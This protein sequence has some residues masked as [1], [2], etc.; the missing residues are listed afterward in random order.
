MAWLT[1]ETHNPKYRALVLRRNSDDLRDWVDRASQL[2]SRLVNPGTKVGNPPEFRFPSGAIIRTGHL[3]D[4]QAYT[5][6]QG[7]EY[8]R[9]LIEELTQIAEERQYLRLLSSCRSVYKELKPQIFLTTNPGGKGHQWVKKRFIDPAPPGITIWDGLR[10]RVFIQATMDDNPTLMQND[11]QYV[12]NIEALKEIDY[13]TYMAWRFGDWDRFAGQVFSEFDRNYHVI[14]P[15]VVRE[16]TPFIWM[17]WG[18]SDVH[19]T[20]FSSYIASVIKS[21]TKDGQ[22]Y[23]QVITFQEICGNR[24]DPEEWARII[25]KSCYEMGIKPK[26]GICDPSMIRSKT[27]TSKLPA[28]L[29]MDEWKRLNG[30]KSWVQ[31]IKGNNART[32]RVGGWAV[33]HKW[34]SKPHGIPFWQI[35]ENCKHLIRTLPMLVYDEHNVEDVDTDMEDHPADACRYGLMNIKFINI[36]P[37]S[38]SATKRNK[39]VQLD[40]DE[41]GLPIINPSKLFGTM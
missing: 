12:A 18:Y 20:T 40:R 41:R 6:Y 23:H 3:K 9:M 1:E 29:M 37:G 26:L 17:D 2:Y 19:E 28:D 39:K 4:D 5:K 35:T 7:H 21:K 32:G 25:Y 22:N 11:P 38:Y 31:L 24:K 15:L 8:Q 27:D 10:S 34:L 16:G 30:N 13:E 36:K 33:M 14:K